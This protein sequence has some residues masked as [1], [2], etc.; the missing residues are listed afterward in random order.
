M[1]VA[2]AL[3]GLMYVAFMMKYDISTLSLVDIRKFP[4]TS[5]TSE[6]PG[7]ISRIV[8]RRIFI[9]CKIDLQKYTCTKQK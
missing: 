7:D 3:E 4:G 2:S 9:D 5:T 6:Y 1:K 8:L